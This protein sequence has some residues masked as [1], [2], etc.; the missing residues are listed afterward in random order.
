MSELAHS[1]FISYA[2]STN[3]A[4]AAALH[5]ALGGD[6]G[7]AF[8]DSSDIELGARFPPAIANAV[9]DARVVVVFADPKYFTRWYCLREFSLALTPFTTQIEPNQVALDHVVVVLPRDPAGDL[10]ELPPQLRS[11]NWPFG[12][13][14][15]AIVGLVKSALARNESSIRDRI[16]HAAASTAIGV[17]IEE[18]LIPPPRSLSGV[19]TF[20]VSLPASI[21]PR[22]VG[23]ANDL[24][25]LHVSLSGPLRS[26]VPVGLTG[27]IEAMGGMGKTRLA[28]EY[29]HRFGH[30]AYP[31]GVFWIYAD[32]DE[33]GIDTQLHGVL[34][35]LAPHTQSLAALRESGTDVRSELGR[36]IASVEKSILFVVDN[37]PDPT[38]TAPLRS[39]EYWCPAVGRVSLLIT[40]RTRISIGAHGVTPIPIAALNSDAALLLLTDRVNRDSLPDSE[41]SAI[42]EWVG[43]LP[44]ALGLLNR[45]LQAAV[46]SPKELAG[47]R[48][49]TTTKQLDACMKALKPHI[50]T[51][52]LG[53]V[54]ETLL[55]SFHRLPEPARFLAL[56]LSELPSMPVPNALIQLVRPARGNDPPPGSDY[57]L[58]EASSALVVRSF[59][60]PVSSGPVSFYGTMHR[61]LADFLRT[62]SP[63]RP[64]IILGWCGALNKVFDDHSDDNAQNWSLLDACVPHSMQL[65]ISTFPNAK[66]AIALGLGLRLGTF[67]QRRGLPQAARELLSRITAATEAEFGAEDEGTARCKAAL[68]NTFLDLGRPTEARVLFQQVADSLEKRLGREHADTLTSLANVA[69][70]FN[71]EG[72]SKEARDLLEWVIERQR[73]AHA[74]TDQDLAELHANLGYILVSLDEFAPAVDTLKRAVAALSDLLGSADDR[75]LAAMNNLATALRHSGSVDEGVEMAKHVYQ[76]RAERLGPKHPHT[77]R[78]YHNFADGVAAAGRL[79]EAIA[80]QRQVVHDSLELFGSSSPVS[81][82]SEGQLATML[83]KAQQF[84]EAEA[85]GRSVAM[86]FERVLPPS[87]PHV[88]TAK[89]NLAQL[90][91][92]LDRAPEAERLLRE[93]FAHALKAYPKDHPFV[94]RAL[95]DWHRLLRKC[96][97]SEDEVRTQVSAAIESM[98][99]RQSLAPSQTSM[100]SNVQD[101]ASVIADARGE[102]ALTQMRLTEPL[103]PWRVPSVSATLINT[104]RSV[105]DS[106]NGAYQGFLAVSLPKFTMS[107]MMEIGSANGNPP[108]RRDAFMAQTLEPGQCDKVVMRFPRVG[109]MLRGLGVDYLQRMRGPIEFRS[110]EPQVFF[111]GFLDYKTLGKQYRLT[112]SVRPRSYAGTDLEPS[113]EWSGTEDLAFTLADSVGREMRRVIAYVVVLE[114]EYSTGKG[115]FNPSTRLTL[116]VGN[117]GPTP[118]RSVKIGWAIGPADMPLD[119]PSGATIDIPTMKIFKTPPSPSMEDAFGQELVADMISGALPVFAHVRLAYTDSWGVSHGTRF[120]FTYNPLKCEFER[121]AE[122]REPM[123]VAG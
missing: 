120:L 88:L 87:H 106:I 69:G 27:S 36:A 19:P 104:G 105:V 65:L 81:T 48:N 56:A 99:G 26:A 33:S 43:R 44:L 54:A 111:T 31:G 11:T 42:C 82:L 14:T 8:L 113:A 70:A 18:A 5:T 21:G 100:A 107:E 25:R 2:R 71:A 84:E 39:P 95:V 90:L 98:T 4:T 96:G 91:V 29:V 23:R 93:V 80:M 103:D 40:A 45:T 92:T 37:I 112:F 49:T 59:V 47:W 28:V 73:E 22:F 108:P 6:D 115:I 57:G 46:T 30:F 1:V 61:V 68:A 58:R 110:Q 114:I 116:V 86:R 12:D 34:T 52:A 85:L 55:L 119:T 66:P 20:P 60:T 72:R 63:D 118:A 122:E 9:L 13:N 77:I 62:Q 121:S 76:V 83:M 79:T 53:G 3:T 89:N 41:W 38:E 10:T 109:A 50:P 35:T 94:G 7:P 15:A 32:A 97:L 64:S 74:A 75:T 102:L 67:L 123:D 16:G 24:W 51:G 117:L 101:Q 78:A 17:L